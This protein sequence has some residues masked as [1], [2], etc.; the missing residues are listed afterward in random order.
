MQVGIVFRK[1]GREL[2]ITFSLDGV[3]LHLG[4]VFNADL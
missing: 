1:G 3:I 4:V 2:Q